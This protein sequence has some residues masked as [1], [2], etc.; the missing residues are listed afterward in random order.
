MLIKLS[1]TITV[2]TSKLFAI[3]QSWFNSYFWRSASESAIQFFK[4][5][6]ILMHWLQNATYIIPRPLSPYICVLQYGCTYMVLRICWYLQ[7]QSPTRKITVRNVTSKYPGGMQVL[8]DKCL[9]PTFLLIVLTSWSI[10]KL[11]RLPCF[12]LLLSLPSLGQCPGWEAFD[13]DQDI[14]AALACIYPLRAN[15][16]WCCY[17]WWRLRAENFRVWIPYFG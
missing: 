11:S 15:E 12:P 1:R 7:L 14:P 2:Y 6:H 3:K 17:K 4:Y 16:V 13:W 10:E 5:T 8:E 9:N